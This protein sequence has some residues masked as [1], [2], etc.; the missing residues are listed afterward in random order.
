MKRFLLEKFK[1]SGADLDVKDRF[2]K[3][4]SSTKAPYFTAE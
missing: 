3:E 4:Y 2:K 1:E